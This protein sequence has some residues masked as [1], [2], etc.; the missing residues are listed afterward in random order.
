MDLPCIGGAVVAVDDYNHR[1]EDVF[2]ASHHGVLA[3]TPR[4]LDDEPQFCPDSIRWGEVITS[5][6][7]LGSLIT[8][9][10]SDRRFS[11]RTRR[12]ANITVTFSTVSAGPVIA[13]SS[14]GPFC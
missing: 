7:F 5:G 9:E 2:R 13:R 14:T 11:H 10:R 6:L 8:G 12:L 3:P 4:F 1:G